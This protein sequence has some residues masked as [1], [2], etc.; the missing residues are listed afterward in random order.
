MSVTKK[1]NNNKKNHTACILRQWRLT[2][3]DIKWKGNSGT[4]IQNNNRCHLLYVN[5]QLKALSSKLNLTKKNSRHVKIHLSSF[6]E[7]GWNFNTFKSSS[8]FILLYDLHYEEGLHCIV[9]NAIAFFLLLLA[10]LSP[11]CLLLS[12]FDKSRHCENKSTMNIVKQIMNSIVSTGSL[13][14]WNA[15]T[16]HLNS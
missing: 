8:L 11:Q 15:F 3:C 1:K 9:M 10:L 6:N 14:N 16:I 5:T 12:V 2:R 4:A 13:S 7:P